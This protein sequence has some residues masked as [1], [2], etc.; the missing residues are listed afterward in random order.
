MLA[1]VQR[2]SM[3]GKGVLH[4]PKSVP[5]NGV[6]EMELAVPAHVILPTMSEIGR[7]KNCSRFF[8]CRTGR[9]RRK[10]DELMKGT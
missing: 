1:S 3:V 4:N 6:L 5:G 10:I 9:R 2:I 7:R 8:Q